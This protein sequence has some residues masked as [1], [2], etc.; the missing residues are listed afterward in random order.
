MD[1]YDRTY[2]VTRLRDLMSEKD[3]LEPVFQCR[4]GGKLKAGMVLCG[5]VEHRC[6]RCGHVVEQTWVEYRTMF[7]Q[8]AVIEVDCPMVVMY[9][10]KKKKR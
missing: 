1:S 2:E 5:L 4:K 3:N 9:R 10:Q 6:L 8:S 7:Q